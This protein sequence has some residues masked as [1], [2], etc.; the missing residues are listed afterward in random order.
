[1]KGKKVAALLI[2]QRNRLDA[3]I[4]SL[5]G[6]A[7]HHGGPPAILNN[8]AKTAAFILFRVLVLAQ[9]GPF[10]S[11]NPDTPGNKHWEINNV[12]FIG[13]RNPFG[14]S[15]ETPNMDFNYGWVIGSSNTKC[16]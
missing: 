13:E 9:G 12:G 7:K 1:L 8:S 14:G 10:L 11:G 4:H 6:P 2:A 15:Y 5:E 3:A 16:P